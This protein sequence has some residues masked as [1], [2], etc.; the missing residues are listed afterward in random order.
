MVQ[1]LR[2]LYQRFIRIRGT[3]REISLGFALGLFVGFSPTMGVQIAI[4]VFLASLFKW[5]KFTAAV[6]VQVTNPLT[7]PVLYGFTYWIG[8]KL[9]GLQKT[10]DLSFGM[11]WHS[12]VTM[13]EQAPR[14]FLALT[15]GGVIVGLPAAAMGYAV[16]YIAVDRYRKGIKEKLARHKD[17]LKQKMVRR[18]RAGKKGP[19]AGR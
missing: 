19:T 6:G 11:D 4:A 9:M 16:C 18:K 5:N 8:A 12:V 17:R 14:I 3:P 2:K 13:I 7:A 15:I 10:L 1:L